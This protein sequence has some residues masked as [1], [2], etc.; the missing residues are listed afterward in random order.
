MG[1]EQGWT[2]LLQILA[3]RPAD[4]TD[5]CERFI[6]RPDVDQGDYP[7]D[8]AYIYTQGSGADAPRRR[9]DPARSAT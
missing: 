5:R 3:L 6:D 4:A 1:F 7:F 9:R 2:S 8:R